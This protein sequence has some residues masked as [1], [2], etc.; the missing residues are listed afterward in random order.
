MGPFSSSV[1]SDPV[2]FGVRI[3]LSQSGRMWIN[4]EPCWQ[5]ANTVWRCREGDVMKGL[6]GSNSTI[7]LTPGFYISASPWRYPP[8]LPH[9]SPAAR[10]CEYTDRAMLQ[11]TGPQRRG[12]GC[13]P[14]EDNGCPTGGQMRCKITFTA[15]ICVPFGCSRSQFIYCCLMISCWALLWLN[16]GTI[17]KCIQAF[18]SIPVIAPFPFREASAFASVRRLFFAWIGLWMMKKHLEV[19][20]FLI[21]AR[22]LLVRRVETT[23]I[24]YR[25]DFPNVK[26]T[27]QQGAGI[28]HPIWS[29]QSRRL[30]PFPDLKP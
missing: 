3:Q 23:V 4:R 18:L 2:P 26:T 25:F 10:N 21:W 5:R 6:T 20:F 22:W 17:L 9:P 29:M 8:P 13:H 27:R 14:L 30:W 7:F 28:I 19:C 11:C 24:I 1:R 16:P 15:S 12:S